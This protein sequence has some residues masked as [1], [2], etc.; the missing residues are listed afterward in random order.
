MIGR[1]VT[2][3]RH[4]IVGV[5]YGNHGTIKTFG[6]G[7]SVANFKLMTDTYAATADG[8]Y[9]RRSEYHNVQVWNS[10]YDDLY[11]LIVEGNVVMIVGWCS[12]KMYFD[13]T[14]GYEKQFAYTL[15]KECSLLVRA[16]YYLKSRK[17]SENK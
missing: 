12:Q 13:K 14:A 3:N 16:E 2:V 11:E 4:E 17:E 7:K 10:V 1:I 9:E 5:V 15:A 6:T 8:N